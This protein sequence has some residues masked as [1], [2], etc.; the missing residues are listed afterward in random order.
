MTLIAPRR[1]TCTSEIEE[2]LALSI[3]GG[4][5]ISRTPNPEELGFVSPEAGAKLVPIL[6]PFGRLLVLRSITPCL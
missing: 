1:P 4:Q 6:D 5:G 3:Y 2:M